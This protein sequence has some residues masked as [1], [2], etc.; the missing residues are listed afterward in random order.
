[1]KGI[2]NVNVWKIDD[3]NNVIYRISIPGLTSETYDDGIMVFSRGISEPYGY[4]NSEGI[5]IIKYL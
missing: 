4:I 2:D 5:E 1:M 3:G